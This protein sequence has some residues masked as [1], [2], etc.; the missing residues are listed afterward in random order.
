[1]TASFGISMYV[2]RHIHS[3]EVQCTGPHARAKTSLLIYSLVKCNHLAHQ[4]R[5]NAREKA[6][7]NP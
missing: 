7:R 5:I 6:N 2:M 1:M 4:N 3:A